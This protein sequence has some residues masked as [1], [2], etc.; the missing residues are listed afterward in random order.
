M[1]EF[2]C[3]E[4]QDFLFIV[5]TM[6]I[7]SLIKTPRELPEIAA[8]MS[9]AVEASQLL[10]KK[11]SNLICALEFAE[12]FFPDYANAPRE[13]NYRLPSWLNWHDLTDWNPDERA[14][15][16]CIDGEWRPV[17]PRWKGLE[18]DNA[19]ALDIMAALRDKSR[20]TVVE[21][22]KA[23]QLT[24]TTIR[25]KLARLED[26]TLVSQDRA[27]PSRW[28]LTDLSANAKNHHR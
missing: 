23:L 10:P 22:A 9:R 27:R 16:E 15:E 14:I 18:G 5:Q 21:L 19:N 1:S 12:A 3:S 11:C 13:P 25:K 28:S 26:L 24:D 20:Q 8:L 4:R 17:N 6:L 7:A 2:V